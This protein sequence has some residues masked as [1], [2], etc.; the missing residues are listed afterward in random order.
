MSRIGD[1]LRCFRGIF[2]GAREDAETEEELRFHLEMET[3]KNVRAGMD[4][5][6][7]GRLAHVRLGSV[8]ALREAVR[9]ARGMRTLWDLRRDIGYALRAARRA[10]YFGGCGS[11]V[12]LTRFAG[13]RHTPTGSVG[14]HPTAS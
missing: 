2:R 7:A 12:E 3:E 13:A 10:A 8:D 4:R 6:E 14:L 9:D 5:R 11:P 1:A